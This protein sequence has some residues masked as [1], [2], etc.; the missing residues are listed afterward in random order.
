MTPKRPPAPPDPLDLL[1]LV[2][3][4]VAIIVTFLIAFVIIVGALKGSL[5]FTA[6][7]TMLG[8]ILT[9]MFGIV[10]QYQL[11]RNKRKDKEK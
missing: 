7:A 9:T 2:A 6:V 11:S 10:V 5:N 3:V 8:G 1:A 4:S